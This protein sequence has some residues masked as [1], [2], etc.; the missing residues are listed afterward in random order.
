[1]HAIYSIK[2]KLS[3]INFE[4]NIIKN[5][6]PGINKN[7]EE[8]EDEELANMNITSDHCEDESSLKYDDHP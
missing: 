1:M 5:K 6:N 7:E 4:S 2:E 8:E 3:G